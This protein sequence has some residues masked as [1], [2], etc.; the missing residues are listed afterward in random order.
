MN[1]HQVKHIIDRLSFPVDSEILGWG[2][3]DREVFSFS[4]NF[5]SEMKNSFFAVIQTITNH[6][7]YVAPK[8]YRK[9]YGF[10]KNTN[11]FFSTF[12][13]EMLGK[14]LEEYLKTENGK[15]SLIIILTME[16]A[17]N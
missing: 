15:N 5:L 11:N 2:L 12:S 17:K 16:T 6:H 4:L 14:F 13:D 9:N 8:S 7:P 1:R 10:D 3:S